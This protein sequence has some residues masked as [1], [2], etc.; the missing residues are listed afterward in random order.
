[1]EVVQ[2]MSCKKNILRLMF[3]G[4]II[5][6]IVASYYIFSDIFGA[7]ALMAFYIVP[8]QSLYLAIPLCILVGMVSMI[9]VTV[10]LTAMT[11]E[12]CKRTLLLCTIAAYMLQ[13]YVFTVVFP[14]NYLRQLINDWPIILYLLI[15]LAILSLL[16]RLWERIGKRRYLFWSRLGIA[17]LIG[18]WSCLWS[19]GGFDEHQKVFVLIRF[20]KIITGL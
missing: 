13:S 20:L 18:L 12:T 17:G 3:L 11:K 7:L 8:S 15:Q 14:I 9:L 4:S 5:I 16:R 10:P 2:G 1:M 6:Y 19:Y